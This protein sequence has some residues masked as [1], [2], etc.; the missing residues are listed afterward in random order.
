MAGE[1]YELA[2]ESPEA[3]GRLTKGIEAAIAKSFAEDAKRGERVVMTRGEVKRRTEF[4]VEVAR[5]LRSDLGWSVVR[6]VDELPRALRAK[7]DGTP[8]DPKT[9]RTMW[10]PD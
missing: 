6:I 8:W 2:G 4:C 7:L 1:I 3:I 9:L 10:T 5:A